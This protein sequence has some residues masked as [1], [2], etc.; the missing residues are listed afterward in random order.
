MGFFILTGAMFN[1]AVGAGID[2]CAAFN[3]LFYVFCDCFAVDKLKNLNRTGGDAFP[4]S[5]TFIIID[6]DCDCSFFE[7]LLHKRHTSFY[8]SLS[9]ESHYFMF[10]IFFLIACEIISRF[11]YKISTNVTPKG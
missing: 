3:A 5:F 2:T 8:S 4:G 10:L 7:F 9:N 11:F 6:G 1:C